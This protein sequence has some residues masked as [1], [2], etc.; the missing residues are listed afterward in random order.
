MLYIDLY[1]IWIFIW[2]RS[3]CEIRKN[4]DSLNIIQIL[5]KSKL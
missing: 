2:N 1:L 4:Y 5:Y 3:L